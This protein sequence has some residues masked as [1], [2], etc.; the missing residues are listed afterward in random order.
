[1]K[2]RKHLKRRSNGLLAF[3][4]IFVALSVIISVAVGITYICIELTEVSREKAVVTKLR[5]KTTPEWVDVQII[6]ETCG[7]RTGEKLESLRNIVIHYVGN[8]STTAQENHDYFNK[9][10]TKVSSHFIIGL[11]GEIIQ[12][13]PIDEES[14][15]SNWRNKDTISIEVCHPYEDGKFNNATYNSLIKLTSWLCYTFYLDEDDVIR[16]HDITGKLCP[17]YYVEN[18]WAWNDL[19]EDIGRKI[20]E[21]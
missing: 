18:E 19:K 3:L 11:D 1:M 5:D 20:D 13:V 16:H 9:E 17:L 7:G 15:A 8:P 4:L 14:A 6:G 12:C 10:R 2:K 21:Y